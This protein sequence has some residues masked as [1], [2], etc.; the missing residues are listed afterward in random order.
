MSD[1]L[2]RWR[3]GWKGTD[4]V[5]V[6]RRPGGELGAESVRIIEAAGLKIDYSPL[7]DGDGRLSPAVERAE[8][9]LSVGVPFDA[10][11]LA[12]LP[13]AR[14]LLRPYVG[15]DDLDVDAATELGILVANVPDTFIIEVAD[16]TLA[17][18]LAANRKLFQMDAFIR[19]GRWASGIDARK[20]AA[21]IRR[22]ST[23]TLGLVGFGGIGRLVAQ[24]AAPFGFR[25]VAADPF[26]PASVAAEYGVT[27]LPLDDVLREADILSIHVFLS[28]QT[29][30]LIDARCFA[31]MKPS[32]ILVNTSRGPVVDEGALIE[33]LK[34]GA[35]A[36]AALDVMEE[37]PLDPASPLIGMDNVILA[38]HLA[39]YSVEGGEVH[40]ER[41]GQLAVQAATGLLERKVVINK[42]LYDRVAGLPELADARRF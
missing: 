7:R 27:L 32:A 16:H 37:E 23:L 31:L 41:V 2:H 18:L 10:E 29:R 1:G 20:A 15:Y 9:L 14:L 24:R 40:R 19:D 12:A 4:R 17:L 33:A 38:P 22:L 26:V 34:A 35:I 42:D 28:R 21:P 8:V 36:G 3:Q 39:S 6:A 13:H 5:V 25:I 30:H 11:T